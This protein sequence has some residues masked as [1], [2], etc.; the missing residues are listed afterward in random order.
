MTQFEFWKKIVIIPFLMGEEQNDS[1][2]IYFK[3]KKGD[4][5]CI[6]E[7]TQDPMD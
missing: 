3:R 1:E 2:I 7:S 5:I 6:M 4:K